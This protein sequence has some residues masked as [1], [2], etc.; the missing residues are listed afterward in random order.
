MGFRSRPVCLAATAAFSTAA[1]ATCFAL[2]LD[3]PH[4]AVEARY[5]AD[6]GDPGAHFFALSGDDLATVEQLAADGLL[7]RLHTMGRTLAASR[8]LRVDHVRSCLVVV[9]CP[10]NVER[11][12]RVVACLAK[13]RQ[14]FVEFPIIPTESA[15]PI[16]ANGFVEHRV[17][18]VPFDNALGEDDT[19]AFA[20]AVAA[21]WRR[22]LDGDASPSGGTVRMD[23]DT[24]EL[25]AAGPPDRVARLRSPSGDASTGGRSAQ[26]VFMDRG[27]AVEASQLAR[28]RYAGTNATVEPI[29]NLNA[30][31]INASDEFLRGEIADFA[32]SLDASAE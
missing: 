17:R 5:V 21:D 15:P 25:V 29:E 14:A 23:W 3:P 9:D 7:E 1:A 10:E 18:L 2:Q 22:I 28:E 19:R 12:C 27:L 4:A 13:H 8:E 20:N 16:D 11:L 32:K 26:I 30:V 31:F 6:C 24:C